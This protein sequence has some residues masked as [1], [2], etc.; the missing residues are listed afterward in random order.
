[1]QEPPRIAIAQ[2]S[3]NVLENPYSRTRGPKG[4]NKTVDVI[5]KLD[6]FEILK[7]D[8]DDDFFTY[9][10]VRTKNRVKGYL[11]EGDSFTVIEH[12]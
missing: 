11:F 4:A 8:R 5:G 10:K 2:A 9:Y 12:H 7:Q 3:L 1:M 6:T